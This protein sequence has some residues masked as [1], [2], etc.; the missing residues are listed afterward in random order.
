MAVTSRHTSLANR[1]IEK[2][3]GIEITLFEDATVEDIIHGILMASRHGARF[4]ERFAPMLKGRDD[5]ATLRNVWE[6]VRRNIAYQRDADGHEIIKSPGRTWQDRFGDCK[7]MSVKVASLL[8]NLGFDYFFRVA[9]YDPAEPN[10][11]HIYPVV[12]LPGGGKVVV[13]AV[14]PRFDMEY[15]WWKK[16]DYYPPK[17]RISGLKHNRKIMGI[18]A[19]PSFGP[20]PAQAPMTAPKEFGLIIWKAPDEVKEYF[21]KWGKYQQANNPQALSKVEAAVIDSGR[22][23]IPPAYQMALTAPGIYIFKLNKGFNPDNSFESHRFLAL[24]NSNDNILQFMDG[25]IMEANK[26]GSNGQA[27]GN[28]LMW[29]G[30]AIALMFAFSKKK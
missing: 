1:Y 26:N 21:K 14:H 17:R 11:G 10:Q 6:F 4:T 8:E 18:N 5:M 20:M 15:Q 23:D 29:V 7:S 16:R 13:D 3:P 2:S 12:A 30:L 9:F 27:G 19:N 25:I 28:G 22:A 24:P